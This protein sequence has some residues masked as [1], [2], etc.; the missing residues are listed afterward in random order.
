MIH[1]IAFRNIWRNKLRSWVVITSIVLGIFGG[2]AVIST[3]R[4]LTKMRQD[5]AIKTYV[6]HIQ[7]HNPQYNLLGEVEYTLH[8]GA[9]LLQK[10]KQKEDVK[11]VAGRLK[12]ESFVQSA[13]GNT[14]LILN[15]VLPADEKELTNILELSEVGNFLEDYKRKPPIVLSKTQAER[16]NVKLKSTVQCTFTNHKGEP[17]TAGFKVVDIYETTNTLYDQVNAFVLLPKLQELVGLQEIH[18]I[19]L[20]LNDEDQV[21]DFR[22]ELQSSYPEVEVGSWRGIAPELGYAEKMMDLVM[23]I[24]LIIIMLALAFGIINTML[25]AVLERRKELGMLLSVG[26][27]KKKVFWMIIWESIYLAMIAG[28]IGIL[29]AYLAINFFNEVGIDLSFAAKGL[30]SVGLGSTIY[31]YLDSFYYIFIALLVIATSLLSCIYP[32][33]K[34]LK[35]NPSETLRTAV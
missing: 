2:L 17:V 30:N 33:R 3:A 31:P 5:N 29:V 7:I 19:A 15:G 35:L 14:G 22:K 27:N 10:L 11:A 6:S 21:R 24:F 26:M 16:L 4:G 20:M 25:M 18:Q 28:P 1:K 8:N 12:V 34:A 32:A 9:E 13:R 23:T